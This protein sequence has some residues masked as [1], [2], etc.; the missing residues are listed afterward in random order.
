MKQYAVTIT[1]MFEAENKIEAQVIADE[2]C[3]TLGGWERVL[4]AY[5]ETAVAEMVDGE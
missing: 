3:G 2:A 4:N 1:V 5:V